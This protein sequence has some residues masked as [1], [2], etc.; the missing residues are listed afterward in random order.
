MQELSFAPDGITWQY[1]AELLL[2]FDD[3]RLSRELYPNTFRNSLEL[4]AFTIVLADHIWLPSFPKAKG[5]SLT[6]G[7]TLRSLTNERH[8]DVRLISETRFHISDYIRDEQSK[9]EII[10]FL[11]LLNRALLLDQEKLFQDYIIREFA[12]YFDKNLSREAAPHFIN[13]PALL[14]EVPEEFIDKMLEYVRKSR[15]P[16]PADIPT[17]IEF[18]RKTTATHIATS[19]YRSYVLSSQVPSGLLKIPHGTRAL[20]FGAKSLSRPSPFNELR[21]LLMPNLLFQALNNSNCERSKVF[22]ALIDLRESPGW[23]SLSS[24]WCKWSPVRS[25]RW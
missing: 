2:N 7:G 21:D 3:T 8:L 23:K 13:D 11:R 18:I 6:A 20:V 15:V 4:V 17:Q 12:L 10:R 19:P 9:K 25:C 1:G 14:K 5:K 16:I 24:P 22:D